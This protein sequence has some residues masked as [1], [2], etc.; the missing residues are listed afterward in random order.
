MSAEDLA[1]FYVHTVSVETLQDEGPWGPVYAPAHD[2]PCFVDE[3]RVLVRDGNGA[4][5]VSEATLTTGPEHADRFTPGSL[6]HVNGR[7]AQVIKASAARSLDLDLPDHL[8]V[9]LT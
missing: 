7:T 5:V 3:T 2:V 6:V 9:A 1:E 8:E 4:E